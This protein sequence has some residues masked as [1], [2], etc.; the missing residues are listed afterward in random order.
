MSEGEIQ[1]KEQNEL[2]EQQKR[3][4]DLFFQSFRFSQGSQTLQSD[5]LKWLVIKGYFDNYDIPARTPDFIKE[6][7]V[8]KKHKLVD[9]DKVDEL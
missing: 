7:A 2:T 4:K 5:I 9:D 8:P 1:N 3:A 6:I